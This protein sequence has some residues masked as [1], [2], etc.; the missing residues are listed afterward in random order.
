VA[1]PVECLAGPAAVHSALARAPREVRLGGRVPISHCF[2]G[3]ASA[4]DVQNLGAIVITATQETAD[5]VRSAP[6]SH[7]AVELGYLVGAIRRGAGPGFGI[8]YEAERRVEQELHG[9]PTRTP[10]FRRGLA[11]GR[12]AG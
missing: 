10:E 5:R 4:A 2:Q 1:V 8:H 3:A 6:R 11:A 7:A 9:V 12:R